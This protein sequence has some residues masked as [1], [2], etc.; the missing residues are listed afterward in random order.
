MR[1]CVLII[2]ILYNNSKQQLQQCDYISNVTCFCFL[3][4]NIFSK[5]NIFKLLS[6]ISH[7]LKI[8]SVKL[9]VIVIIVF[10]CY[11]CTSCLMHGS[12]F[13]CSDI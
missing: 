9:L 3:D 13:I 11:P 8:I 7:K 10:E 5:D 4:R 1:D 2:H 6:S 12:C